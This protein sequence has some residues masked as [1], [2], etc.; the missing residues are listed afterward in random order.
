MEAILLLSRALLSNL[1]LSHM[2]MLFLVGKW[3]FI[4]IEWLNRQYVLQHGMHCLMHMCSNCYHHWINA[5]ETWKVTWSLLRY[6]FLS[7]WPFNTVNLRI[8]NLLWIHFESLPCNIFLCAAQSRICNVSYF[9]D[10]LFAS[11]TYELHAFIL[12]DYS[13]FL[14]V[15]CYP[16]ERKKWSSHCSICFTLLLQADEKI[17]ESYAKSWTSGVLDKAAQRD[18][19]AYTLVKHQL[20]GFVFQCSASGKTL[21]YKVVKSLLRCF[22]QKRHHEVGVRSSF[23]LALL[24]SNP[25]VF[26]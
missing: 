20:S 2:E 22:T 16:K 11:Y 12:F 21:R 18:S 26:H 9:A 4:C 3:P 8:M 19:M 13:Y 6:D 23:L 15:G 1:Q 7:G 10:D 5:L 14:A 17:L 24:R 25:S